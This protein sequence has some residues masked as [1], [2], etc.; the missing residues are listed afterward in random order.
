MPDITSGQ[1]TERLRHSMNVLA[2]KQKILDSTRYFV[3]QKVASNDFSDTIDGF[4][5]GHR[6]IPGPK[7]DPSVS[8]YLNVRDIRFLESQYYIRFVDN[9]TTE[10]ADED[11]RAALFVPM[12]DR[13]AD[14]YEDHLRKLRGIK[15]PHHPKS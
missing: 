14:D 8:A 7:A 13:E 5:K 4:Y 1:L 2:D 6:V 10:D 12:T 11:V 3:A 15:K 9:K